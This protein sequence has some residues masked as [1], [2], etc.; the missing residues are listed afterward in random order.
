MKEDCISSSMTTCSTRSTDSANVDC[1]PRTTRLRVDERFLRVL[2]DELPARLHVLAHEDAEHAVG[3]CGVLQRDLLQHPGLRVH[4]RIPELLGIHLA[5]PLESLDL[6]LL[7]AVLASQLLEGP[8]VV[9]VVVLAVDLGP[10][11]GW[12]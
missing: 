8:I 10:V 7:V 5:E 1:L 2:L 6:E 3:L 4:R 11:Q 9:H 12:L